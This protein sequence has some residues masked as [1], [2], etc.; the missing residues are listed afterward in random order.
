[1]SF[2]T[3]DKVLG[4]NLQGTEMVVLSA[5]NTGL[6]EVKAGE[7]VFGLRRAFAQAGAKS[8]VMSMW[9]VPD[10]ETK[11]MMIQFYRNIYSK[12]MNRLQALREATLNQMKIVKN[13]YGFANP[14]YWGGFVFVGEP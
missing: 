1:M 9:K 5:C 6:G 13:R 11:E 8:M 7:G 12:K 3:S 4:L 2:I 14:L 10:L